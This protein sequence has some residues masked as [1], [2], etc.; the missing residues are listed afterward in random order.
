MGINFLIKIKN[1]SIQILKWDNSNEYVKTKIHTFNKLSSGYTGT[2]VR[3]DDSLSVTLLRKCTEVDSECYHLLCLII[4]S[5]Y[6]LKA[7]L[8][9]KQAAIDRLKI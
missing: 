5:I 6:L 2:D 7:E 1:G 3:Y 4:E 9:V 8:K